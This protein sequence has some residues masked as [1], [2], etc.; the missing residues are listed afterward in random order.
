MAEKLGLPETV[1]LHRGAEE[2]YEYVV[3][4]MGRLA[5]DCHLVHRGRLLPVWNQ[6]STTRPRRTSH[7]SGSILESKGECCRK[8][9]CPRSCG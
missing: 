3:D 9:S 5:I 2:A 4:L 1:T 6:A 8:R 7:S